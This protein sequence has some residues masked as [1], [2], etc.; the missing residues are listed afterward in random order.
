MFENS[1]H[2][3]G[4]LTANPEVRKAGESSVCNFTVALNRMTK[5][6]HPES[7]YVDCVAWNTSAD[8]ISKYFSKGDRIGIEGSLRTRTYEDK[9]GNNRKATEVFVE[10]ATFIEKKSGGAAKPET[11]RK[12]APEVYDDDDD[13]DLPF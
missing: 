8:F 6:E 10:R 2:L 4:R 5:K 1:V 12:P 13:E 3:M 9:N 11:A 7:D